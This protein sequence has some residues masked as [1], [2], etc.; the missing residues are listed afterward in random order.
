MSGMT[1]MDA[2]ATLPHAALADALDEAREYTDS[3]L[4]PLNDHEL[5]RQFTPLQSPLAWD[6]AHIAHYEELW[7]VR[8]ISGGDATPSRKR[9]AVR[10]AILLARP[11][12]G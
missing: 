1:P 2:I 10:T 5:M 9:K 11:Q 3:L 4:E 6:L 8:E 7:L 12:K